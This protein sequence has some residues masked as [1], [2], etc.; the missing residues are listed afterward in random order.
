MN[1]IIAAQNKHALPGFD[2]IVYA[3]GEVTVLDCCRLPGSQSREGEFFCRPL[4]DASIES[5]EKYGAA[6]GVCR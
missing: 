4:C 5:I 1:I 3:N 6:A 2:C